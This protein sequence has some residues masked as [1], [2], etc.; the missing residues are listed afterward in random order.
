MIRKKHRGETVLEHYKPANDFFNE[1]YN[2]KFNR[3]DAE[4]WFREGVVAIITKEE[5]AKLTKNG[6]WRKREDPKKAYK[7]C[8]IEI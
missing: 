5:D 2:K 8:G 6:Y 3:D 4:R 1:F 7:E